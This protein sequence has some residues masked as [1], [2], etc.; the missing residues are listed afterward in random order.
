MPVAVRILVYPAF[1]I[2]SFILFLL[3]LFPFD[4]V[5]L[6][7]ASELEKS[8]GGAYEIK[9]D[10]MSPAPLSGVWFKGVSITPRKVADAI[11]FKIKKAKVK[12]ALIPLLSGVLE[13]DFD[14]VAEKGSVKGEYAWRRGPY[15]IQLKTDKFDLGL[16]SALTSKSGI[17]LSGIINGHLSLSIDPEDSLNNHGTIHLQFPELTLGEMTTSDGAFKVPV[18]KLAKIDGSPATL[19]TAIV[20]GNID[21]T[22]LKFAGGDLELGVDGKVYGAKKWDNYRFNL[23]GNFKVT[24]EVSDQVPILALIEKQKQTDGQFPFTLTGRVTCPN[25]R[26]G[27]FKLPLNCTP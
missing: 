1:L 20:K 15:D 14:V 17:N 10:S 2:F 19:D 7:T 26:I 27:E 23:K 21:L 12:I 13:I 16:I 8:M 3:V 5:R 6:R 25:I 22:G 9:I 18:L 11:P 4:S 24:Q